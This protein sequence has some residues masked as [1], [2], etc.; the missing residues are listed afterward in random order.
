MSLM[1]IT[2]IYLVH[3]YED[4]GEAFFAALNGI[5]SGLII[6]LREKRVVLFND[7]Y[8][9]GRIYFH[10][11]VD[12]FY[13]ASEAKALLKVLPELRQLDMRGLA[14]YFACDCV[15]QDRTLFS[16]IRLL[17]PGSAW[18]FSSRQP[19]SKRSYFDPKAWE[20]QPALSQK[21]Y[22]EKLK[23]SFSRVLPRPFRTR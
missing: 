18:N 23:I 16:G 6:D 10:Q 7:R 20:N 17:P 12:G 8:G 19:A 14:E 13:F 11:T 2:P 4:T 15:L 5:F 22:Y 9:M 21:D 1:R 3:L